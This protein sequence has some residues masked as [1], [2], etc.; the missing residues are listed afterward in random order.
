VIDLRPVRAA[1]S[2]FLSQHRAAVSTEMRLAAEAGVAEVQRKPGFKRRTGATQAATSGKV[3]RTRS[4][5]VV[6]LRNPKPH[7]RTLEGGSRAHV[8]R[9]RRAKALRFSSNGRLVFAK[10]VQHPG[11]KPYR[12]LSRARDTASDSF[13]RGMSRSMAEIARRF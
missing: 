4:G 1:H 6:R 10:S 3:I 12:F 11:T 8:I 5:G 9:A 13:L 2:R 7:A